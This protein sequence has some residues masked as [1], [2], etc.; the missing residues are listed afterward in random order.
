ML[1]TSVSYDKARLAGHKS[2]LEERK[3]RLPAA[4]AW[5]EVEIHILDQNSCKTAM[6]QRRMQ[7][8]IPLIRQSFDPRIGPWVRGS[9]LDF[10]LINGGMDRPRVGKRGRSSTGRA[11]QGIGKS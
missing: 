7:V 9:R 2:S 8:L 11:F 1:R 10:I 5:T 6:V 3:C 4:S